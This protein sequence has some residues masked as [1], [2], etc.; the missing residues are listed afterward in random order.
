[1]C[2]LI[3]VLTACSRETTPPEAPTLEPLYLTETAISLQTLEYAE[4]QT[5]TPTQTSTPTL[6]LTPIPTFVRTRPPIFTPT[7]ELPCNKAAAGQPIDVTIPDDTTLRSGTSFSKTWRLVNVGACTWTR[8]YAITFF[9]GNSLGARHTQYLTEP[10]E[11]GESV[12]VTVDMVAPDKI[13]LFQSNWMISDPAGNLFGI[14]PHGDAPFWVRIEVVLTATN[15]PTPTPTPIVFIAAEMDLVNGDR[16]DLDTATLNPDDELDAD[17]LYQFGSDPTYRL[18]P[19]NG[20]TWVVIEDKVPTFTD[21]SN[22][23]MTADPLTFNEVPVGTYLCYRTNDDLPGRILI[24]G[25]EEEKITVSFVTWW[26]P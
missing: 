25:F 26:E 20:M 2:I 4:T 6:T 24:E 19:I 7:G 14:G 3:L 22:A 15:T 17:L 10:V 16:L 23:S 8:Q 11:P 1:M 5:R 21:C 9:S 13:G 12:N 18:I